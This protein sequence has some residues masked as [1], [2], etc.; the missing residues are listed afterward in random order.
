MTHGLLIKYLFHYSN[1]VVW[2][3]SNY[4]L[5][6]S[7]NNLM[8]WNHLKFLINLS[9]NIPYLQ[10]VFLTGQVTQS[11]FL[12]Y[13]FLSSFTASFDHMVISFTFTS[14]RVL[15]ATSINFVIFLCFI[16]A[17]QKFFCPLLIFEEI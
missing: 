13:F 10:F 11:Y 5:N 16:E 9:T 1:S 17:K 15:E 7:V 2:F 14:F 3:E 6:I 12:L 8:V 4:I